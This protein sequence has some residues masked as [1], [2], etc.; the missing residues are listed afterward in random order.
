[1]SEFKNED[2]IDF[3]KE[4]NKELLRKT[5]EKVQKELGRTYPFII[6][7]KEFFEGELVESVNPA[8]TKELI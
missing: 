7:G 4:E 8:N 6:G 2:Y 3:S 5:V 1:M